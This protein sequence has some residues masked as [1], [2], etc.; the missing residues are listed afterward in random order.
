M[1]IRK[2][3]IILGEPILAGE[4][5]RYSEM[6]YIEKHLSSQYSYNKLKFTKWNEQT[7]L[8]KKYK[9]LVHK[10]HC[11]SLSPNMDLIHYK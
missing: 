2:M 1:H 7:T 6:Q 8:Y 10:L 3:F 11:Y 9:L 5:S 4:Q